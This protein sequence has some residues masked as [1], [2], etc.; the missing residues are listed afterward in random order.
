MTSIPRSFITP[1]PSDRFPNDLTALNNLG[2][3]RER[4]GQYDQALA[5]YRQAVEV[6]GS[7]VNYV[8]LASAART[9]GMT[10]LA[11]S[12]VLAML[13]LYPNTWNTWNTQIQTAF[14]AGNYSWAGQIAIDMLNSEFP[15]PRV[16]GAYMQASLSAIRGHISQS[17]MFADS[18]RHMAVGV[19]IPFLHFPLWTAQ[20]AAL[21]AGTPEAAIPLLDDAPRPQSLGTAPRFEYST[22]GIL[23]N[24]YA[25]AGQQDVAERILV[26]MDSLVDAVGVRPHGIGS[27]VRAMIA[28]QDGRPESSLEYLQ[29]AQDEEF[30]LIRH[31]AR[32]LLAQTY[33][34]LE[35]WNEAAAQ[36]DSLSSSFHLNYQDVWRLRRS[37]RWRS[38]IRGIVSNAR[39]HRNRRGAPG[40]IY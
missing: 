39:R 4:M 36:Y 35:R 21:A 15:F 11:D 27:Q 3:T 25:L 40:G 32:F 31:T 22:L 37:S 29:Q 23:A 28:L 19:S 38:K 24:G 18:S 16:F 14:Y 7:S 30:G 5:L 8:N 10:R 2:D 9:L 20:Y 1:W 17:I 6:G 34:A 12:V 33:E 13:D 26:T